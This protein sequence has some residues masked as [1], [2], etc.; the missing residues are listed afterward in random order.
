MLSLRR[1]RPEGPRAGSSREGEASPLPT[2]YEIWGNTVSSPIV[3]SGAELWEI[4]NLVHFG[5]WKSHQ[6]SVSK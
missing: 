2:S 6:N 4:V 1:S 3:G 5:S